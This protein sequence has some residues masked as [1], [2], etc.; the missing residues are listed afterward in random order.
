MVVIKAS[1]ETKEEMEQLL[2][3]LKTAYKLAKRPKT[4]EKGPYKRLYVDLENK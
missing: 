1:C 4:S 2:Q 3:V